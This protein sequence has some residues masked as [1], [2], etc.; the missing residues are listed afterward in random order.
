MAK[1]AFAVATIILLAFGAIGVFYRL[2][3]TQAA[4]LLVDVQS[5]GLVEKKPGES[6][7]VKIAFENQ[8][9]ASGKWKI[10][11]TLEG[12]DWSWI[13]NE[14]QL[15]LKP[16]RRHTLKWSGAVPVQARVDSIS[17][18]IVYSDDGFVR[19]DWWIHVTAVPIS[20]LCIVDSEVT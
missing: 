20:E 7:T 9:T 14:K 10:A 6:F 18:L 3:S 4:S 8:G 15:F 16:H 1:K 5:G 17:R 13:G 11:V 19:L 12:E 2:D